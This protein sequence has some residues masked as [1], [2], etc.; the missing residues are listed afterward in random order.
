MEK[1]I[2]FINTPFQDNVYKGRDG[3][4]N[5]N[6]DGNGD[7][8]GYGYGN[9]K[10]SG[11]GSGNGSGC[12]SGNWSGY[13]SGNGFKNG[14]GNG[15]G[16]GYGHGYGNG[17]GSGSGYEKGLNSLNNQPIYSIDNIQTIISTLRGNIAKGFIVQ[18]DLSLTP[19][20]IV[21][22]ENIFSHGSTLKKAYESLRSK[23]MMNLSIKDRITKFKKHFCNPS[24]YYSAKDFYK[25]HNLL[26][27]SC[28][29]GLNPCCSG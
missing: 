20:F 25:W 12:G 15:Y 28:E 18:N 10:G 8:S 5:E 1:I 26:T 16:S 13:G 24:S 17:D 21:K 11:Y 9:E 3:S 27:G 6:G 7:G 19:C 14:N 4:R 2:E 22:E 29:L 23:M